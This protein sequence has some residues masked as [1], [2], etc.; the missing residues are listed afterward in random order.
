MTDEAELTFHVDVNVRDLPR[1]QLLIHEWE[2]LIDDMRIG[3]SPF[4]ERAE[5]MLDRFMAD[6][7]KDEA[8]KP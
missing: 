5:H 7:T 3:A 2:A 8:E 1:M 4:A 6:V